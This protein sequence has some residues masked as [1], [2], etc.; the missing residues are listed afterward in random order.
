MKYLP[1]EHIIYKTKF[2]EEEL[3]HR[4]ESKKSK[5]DFKMLF[6]AEIIKA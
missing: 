1:F 4:L 3:L 6:E 2:N 5:N